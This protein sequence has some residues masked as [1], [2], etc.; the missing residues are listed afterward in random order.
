MLILAVA[1][2]LGS[3]GR[4]KGDRYEI[5]GTV[6][7]I[8]TGMVYLQKMDTAG[9]VI[10]DSAAIKNGKF[11]FE[12]SVSSPDQ[13]NFTLRGKTLAFPFFLENSDIQVTLHADSTALLDVTGSVNQAIYS[14]YI[15]RN[16]SIQ[17]LMNAL[18]PL[19]A[20]ADQDKDTVAMNRIDD[21]FTMY[22]NGMK[23]LIVEVAKNNPKC[24]AGPFLVIRN[25]YRF[26]LPE[27]DSLV[28]G[29]DST[30]NASFFYIAAKKR[31]DVLKRVQIG[32]PA[33]DFTMNDTTGN[34]VTVSSFKGK[35]LLIDFWASWCGPCRHE[36]PNVVKAYELFHPKGFDVLGVSFDRDKAKWEEAVR[37]DNLSW[38]HV[39]D[40]KKWGNAAGKLYGVNSIPSNVLLDKDQ[41]I[42]ARNLRGDDLIKKLTELL[43]QPVPVKQK[44][45]V[46]KKK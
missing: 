34:P 8:D 16:D 25:A 26:E 32:K 12:G 45:P 35:I 15:K 23:K 46:S 3:C 14:Q 5:S 13:W 24:A 28:S 4:N 11:E 40:L 36:N 31:V 41:I 10:K 42:V 22:D 18:E 2:I 20:K 19:F 38:T 1:L 37:K 33:V 7:G 17:A 39:S 6:K 30:L 44:H 27:L 9:W 21:Q 29:F 43:G